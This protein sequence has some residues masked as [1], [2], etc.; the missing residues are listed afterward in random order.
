MT[1]AR[2]GAKADQQSTDVVL[3]KLLAAVK[4]NLQSP[5]LEERE[6]ERDHKAQHVIKL[7]NPYN[8]KNAM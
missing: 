6:R 2:N 1:L 7:L 3:S 4:F 8:F 5:A